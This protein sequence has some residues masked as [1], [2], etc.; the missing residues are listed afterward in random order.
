[1]TKILKTEIQKLIFQQTLCEERGTGID[2]AIEACELYQL[3]SPNFQGDKEFTRI[4]LYAPKTLRQ[5][6]KQEKIRACYQHCTLRFV[7]NDYMTNQSL[8]ERFGIEE[9]KFHSFKN[10]TRYN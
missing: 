5:M 1:M 2:K 4:Y 3:P 9:K 10:Y 7:I 6:D 8:R